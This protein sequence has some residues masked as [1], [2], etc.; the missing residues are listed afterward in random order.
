MRSPLNEL[1]RFEGPAQVSGLLIKVSS[2][3]N[4]V[5]MYEVVGNNTA[6]QVIFW[7]RTVGGSYIEE[8]SLVKMNDQ[9]QIC[10]ITVFMRANP[11]LLV[12]LSK[13]APTL[14]SRHRLLRT[15]FV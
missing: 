14:A 15:K 4:G 12:L 11:G 8:A 7:H 5:H 6:A 3:L 1:V 2:L 9:G 10:E 13:I